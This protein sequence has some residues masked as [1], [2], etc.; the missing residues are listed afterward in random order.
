M[1]ANIC[2]VSSTGPNG[3]ATHA[4]TP[5]SAMVSATNAIERVLPRVPAV[6][7]PCTA[8]SSMCASF[9]HATCSPLPSDRVAV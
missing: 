6:F 2:S 1:S 9:L 8:R 4:E 3:M 7:F 5:M